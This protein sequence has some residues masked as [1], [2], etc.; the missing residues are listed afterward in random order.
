MMAQQHRIDGESEEARSGPRG[1]LRIHAPALAPELTAASRLSAMPLLPA[2]LAIVCL[3]GLALLSGAS[4]LAVGLLGVLG[5]GALGL[6]AHGLQRAHA[7][8]ARAGEEARR[9]REEIERLAD[10]MW[11][12]QESDERARGLT[13]ALGDIVVHRDREGRIVYTN[14]V[15]CDLLGRAPEDLCGRRL[16]DL[17]IDIGI[18]PDSAFSDGECLS[19]TDVAIRTREG[20]RWFSWIELSVRDKENDAVSHRAIARDITARKRAEAALISA[21]ERAEAANEAKSRFLATV[22]HEIRTPMN[23][24]MG[25]AHLLTETELTPEQRTYVAAVSTSAAALLALIDDLLDYSKIEFGRFDLEPQPVS[26]HELAENVVELIAPR[27]HGKGI[28][29]GC[30]VAPDVPALIEADPGRLRQVL[31]NIVGNAVKF[32][33]TG[34]VLV[35]VGMTGD[36]AGGKAGD[37]AGRRIRFG[38]ADTGPGIERKDIA[39]LFEEFEQ[40]DGTSTRRHGGTGLGLAISRRIVGAMGGTIVAESEP[41]RGSRFTVEIPAAA[42]VPARLDLA[43][44]LEGRRTVIVSAN[45]MEAQALAL[46]IAAHG[47]EAAIVRTA[48]EAAVD[49][50]DRHGYDIVLVDA[51]LEQSDGRLLKRLRKAGIDRAEAIILIA[52][53]DRG[54]LSEYR[55]CGYGSFLVRPVRGATLLR[56]L[57]SSPAAVAAGGPQDREAGPAAAKTAAA[58][59]TVLVAEDNDI[60][61]LLA[62]SALTKAGHRVEIVPNGKAA[63]EA[64]TQSGGAHRYDVVLMDLHMPVMDGLEAISLIRRHE[65]AKGT[66]AVPILVLSADSQEKTRHGVIAHGATGFLTKPVDPHAMIEAVEGHARA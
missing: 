11:E 35:E 24:I 27:A 23:G 62:R 66:P 34:G 39:R 44:A 61:A 55:A 21:R 48:E 15:L 16:L 38:V 33:E 47:G 40:G 2:F 20:E 18:V 17:G 8:A 63:V 32:T 25:M 12:L 13:D 28:G 19:S 31:I 37:G 42:A 14:R 51:A 56:V 10:R 45:T 50:V 59:L 9:S 41:G 29:L 1:R 64:L 5:S 57:L 54:K 58:G 49:L 60:N 7:L 3:A 46:T 26:P 53:G 65:E 52:P 43:S 36:E 6:Q 4:P 22:S 30:H